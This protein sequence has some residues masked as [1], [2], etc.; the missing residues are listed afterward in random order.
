M[1]SEGRR[2]LCTNI[3]VVDKTRP[4]AEP[5]LLP[6][7]PKSVTGLLAGTGCAQEWHF[8]PRFSSADNVFIYSQ[9]TKMRFGWVLE[10]LCTSL[11]LQGSHLLMILTADS[12]I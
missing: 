10:E 3:D 4:S 2:M 1:V 11:P 7:H 5:Q 12:V 9:N 8:W 6:V